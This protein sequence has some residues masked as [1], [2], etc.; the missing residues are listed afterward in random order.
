MDE[1]NLWRTLDRV[2]GSPP[3]RTPPQPT[4]VDPGQFARILQEEMEGLRFSQHAQ[5]R[6]AS[7]QVQLSPEDMGKIQA[8]VDLVAR[9]GSRDSL[10][11]YRDLALVVSVRNKT[12]IT[13]VS[14]E[15]RKENV[16]TNIDSTV[17]VE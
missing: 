11:L 14:G 3:V 10:I 5:V 2:S 16:F 15:R 17:I 4:K 12:V 1:I 7:G 8:A 13:A 9:K 6:L